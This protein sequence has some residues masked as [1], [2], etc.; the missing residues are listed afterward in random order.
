MIILSLSLYFYSQGQ[1][2]KETEMISYIY[3]GLMSF[4]V[5]AGI[6]KNIFFLLIII[7]KKIFLFKILFKISQKKNYRI[8]PF[9]LQQEEISDLKNDAKDK[10]QEENK[11][12]INI[13]ILKEKNI[14]MKSNINNDSDE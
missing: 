7:K 4:N 9:V 13:E 8:K 11:I 3:L 10:F 2:T 6:V 12:E 14:Q 1:L 5:F